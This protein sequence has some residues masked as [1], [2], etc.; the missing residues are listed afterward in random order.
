MTEETQHPEQLNEVFEKWYDQFGCRYFSKEGHK[1]YQRYAFIQGLIHG[2]NAYANLS[3]SLP[4]AKR[5]PRRSLY[6]Y[7]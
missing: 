4:Q 7:P 6:R 3:N 5:K 2:A 1:D